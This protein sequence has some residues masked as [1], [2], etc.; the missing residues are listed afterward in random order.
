MLTLNFIYVGLSLSG[1]MGEF[2]FVIEFEIFYEYQ[3]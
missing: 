2:E 1:T 3:H